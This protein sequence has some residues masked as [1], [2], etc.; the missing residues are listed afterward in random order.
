M[1]VLL[2]DHEKLKASAVFVRK[3][4]HLKFQGNPYNGGADSDE[5]VLCPSNKALF[6]ID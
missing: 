5:K 2:V 4:R 1:P 6:V 3:E